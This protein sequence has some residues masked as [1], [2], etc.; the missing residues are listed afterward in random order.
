MT[1]KAVEEVGGSAMEFVYK[2]I[3]LQ[4]AV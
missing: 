2:S 3:L 1:K 4:K